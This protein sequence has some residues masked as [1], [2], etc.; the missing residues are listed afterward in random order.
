VIPLGKGGNLFLDYANNV[1]LYP[2]FQ[3]YFRIHRPQ[4]GGGEGRIV[5]AKASPTHTERRPHGR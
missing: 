1:K 2:Q 3:K 5:R 4:M